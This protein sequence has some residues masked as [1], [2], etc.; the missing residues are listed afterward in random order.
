MQLYYSEERDHKWIYTWAWK[1]TVN[2]WNLT[3]NYTKWSNR[4]E[5]YTLQ[6]NSFLLETSTVAWCT[7]LTFTANSATSCLLQSEY[8]F[9]IYA[10]QKEHQIPIAKK[11]ITNWDLNW[12]IFT[13]CE[14]TELIFP[15]VNVDWLHVGGQLYF[16][17]GILRSVQYKTGITINI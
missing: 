13:C 10:M 9:T 11:Y 3:G 5:S 6:G 7:L 17:A 8:T 4:N 16:Q 2:Y 12:N 15:R 1:L 14:K